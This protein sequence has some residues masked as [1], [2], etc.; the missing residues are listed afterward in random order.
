MAHPT[1]QPGVGE[2]HAKAQHGDEQSDGDE[3]L[4][5]GVHGQVARVPPDCSLLRCCGKVSRRVETI[6]CP[7]AFKRRSRS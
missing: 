5:G 6:I 7:E 4:D 3:Q 1:S 2:T